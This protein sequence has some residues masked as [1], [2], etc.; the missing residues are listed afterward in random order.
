MY[1]VCVITHHSVFTNW[2]FKH[3]LIETSFN[4]LPKDCCSQPK[5]ISENIE[6][7]YI[8]YLRRIKHLFI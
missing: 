7:T 1:H 5:R 2:H 8:L 3:A 4:G 6:I